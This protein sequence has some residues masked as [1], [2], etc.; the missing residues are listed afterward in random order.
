MIPALPSTPNHTF[1]C[2]AYFFLSF[3]FYQ[4]RVHSSE[5]HCLATAFASLEAFQQS[6]KNFPSFIPTTVILLQLDSISGDG[7]LERTK[8]KRQP[9]SEN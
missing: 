5:Q 3:I 7:S 9:S 2:V 6:V 4:H 1:A 8:K